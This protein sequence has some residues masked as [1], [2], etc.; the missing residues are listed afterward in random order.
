MIFS[1]TYREYSL[2]KEMMFWNLITLILKL[3]ALPNFLRS[4]KS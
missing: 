3:K 2:S 1:N 4:L